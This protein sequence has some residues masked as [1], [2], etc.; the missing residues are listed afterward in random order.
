MQV[1]LED[2]IAKAVEWTFG[3]EQIIHTTFWTELL[4]L[5]KKRSFSHME[6][7]I[8]ECATSSKLYVFNLIPIAKDPQQKDMKRPIFLC[9]AARSHL[10]VHFSLYSHSLKLGTLHCSLISDICQNDFKY[11]TLKC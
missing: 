10:H 4:V 2:F 3:E 7:A 5:L 6:K 1:D 8:K 9:Y 11:V